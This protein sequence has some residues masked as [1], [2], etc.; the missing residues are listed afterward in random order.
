[1]DKRDR[2]LL[3]PVLQMGMKRIQAEVSFTPVF[4]L[5]LT[6]SDLHALSQRAISGA[7]AA[8]LAGR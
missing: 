3:L 7:G 5:G 1:M 2:S 4:A 6:I 8:A